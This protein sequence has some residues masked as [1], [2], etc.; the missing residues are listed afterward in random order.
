MASPVLSRSGITSLFD[1]S[2]SSFLTP[3]LVRALYAVTMLALGIL[4]LLSV[5]FALGQS[6]LFGLGVLIVVLPCLLILLVWIRVMLEAAV[7]FFQIAER[8][9]EI[10][11]HEAMIAVN[12]TPA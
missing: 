5:V 6:F 9:A 7:V 2:F 3:K 10:A 11:E 8:T 4:G 12:T 1:L